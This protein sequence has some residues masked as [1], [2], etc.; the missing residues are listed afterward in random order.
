M[1]HNLPSSL[2]DREEVIKKLL[3]ISRKNSNKE[4]VWKNQ[5][6]KY[7]KNGADKLVIIH[8]GTK[9]FTSKVNINKK[10]SS[11]HHKHRSSKTFRK[12]IYPTKKCKQQ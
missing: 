6:I 2:P 10:A 11:N 5:Q 8:K 7:I 12:F 4:C 9:K 1:D 3:E